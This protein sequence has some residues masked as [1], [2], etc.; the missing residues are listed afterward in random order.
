VHCFEQFYSDAITVVW[1]HIMTVC[2]GMQ[3]WQL[4]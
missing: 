3:F 4:D 1:L 2:I